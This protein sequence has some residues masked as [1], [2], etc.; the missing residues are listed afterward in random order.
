MLI[1][2]GSNLIS[3]LMRKIAHRFDI[4]QYKTTAYRPQSNGS[5][6]NYIIYYQKIISLT[7]HFIG[8]TSEWD[9]HLGM[10]ISTTT[11]ASMRE[12]T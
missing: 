6:E 9:S 11:L 4:T 2:Q 8:K 12:K 5:I 3:S 1:A 7:K 10:A